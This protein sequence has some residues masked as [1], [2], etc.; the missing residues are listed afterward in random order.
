VR[1]TV[2][3]TTAEEAKIRDLKR[4]P[5]PRET[6]EKGGKRRV[7][8]IL[9]PDGKCWIFPARRAIPTFLPSRFEPR[10]P[11]HFSPQIT[12]FSLQIVTQS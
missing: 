9:R 2:R 7:D 12:R 5:T 4:D 6:R 10:V 11:L 3:V 1:V 8:E